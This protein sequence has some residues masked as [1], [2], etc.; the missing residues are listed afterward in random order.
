MQLSLNYLPPNAAAAPKR[1]SK[2]VP[3]PKIR[4]A[5]EDLSTAHCEEMGSI[6]AQ[7]REK[8]EARDARDVHADSF[9]RRGVVGRR[10]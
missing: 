7:Q 2:R 9:F 5:R 3:L 4:I 10:W 1:G 6:A 8:S